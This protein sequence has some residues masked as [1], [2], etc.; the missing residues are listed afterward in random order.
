MSVLG[1]LSVCLSVCLSAPYNDRAVDCVCQEPV[2]ALSIQF[3]G[4]FTSYVK[5]FT[6]CWIKAKVNLFPCLSHGNF[7][8]T[9]R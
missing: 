4:L 8:T 6:I 2:V 3:L 9:Q 1:A 5:K 7:G